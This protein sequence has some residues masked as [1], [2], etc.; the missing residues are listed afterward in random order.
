MDHFSQSLKSEIFNSPKGLSY[1]IFKE[2]WNFEEYLDL[3]DRKGRI[4]YCK[5][6]TTNHHLPIE[7]NNRKCV[8]C[9]RNDLGDEF[10]FLCVCLSLKIV[11]KQYLRWLI[12]LVYFSKKI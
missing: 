11:R 10:D 1:R 5:F 7:R 6:S 2:E 12:S 3:L 4:N 9:D 8:Y